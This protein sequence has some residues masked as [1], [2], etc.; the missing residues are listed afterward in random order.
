MKKKVMVPFF[1]ADFFL[2]LQ[3]C[4][5]SSISRMMAE[6]VA[7]NFQLLWDYVN[8][9][10]RF[11]LRECNGVAYRMVFQ[12]CHDQV[13]YWIVTNYT[14]VNICSFSYYITCSK[15]SNLHLC[16]QIFCLL[17]SGQIDYHSFIC[18]IIVN[19]CCGKHRT[20][21]AADTACHLRPV[22]SS[23][24]SLFFHPMAMTSVIRSSISCFSTT[25]SQSQTNR[26]VDPL[27]CAYQA[28]RSVED[29]VALG[30]CTLS[31]GHSI[32]IC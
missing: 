28:T 15:G 29:V 17:K 32:H 10:S 20:D 5:I 21:I 27:Q 18:P 1:C 8:D 14:C 30:L 26:L 6:S 16:Q 31:S 7:R 11:V 12:L 13:P 25:C 3:P 9:Y 19:S 24:C 2:M 4:P 23:G 22:L